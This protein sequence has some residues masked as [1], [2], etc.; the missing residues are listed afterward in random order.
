MAMALWAL[1]MAVLG[2]STHGGAI[3][4]NPT[5][6]INGQVYTI[7][8]IDPGPGNALAVG[9]I[10]LTAGATFQ[11]DYQA[12]VSDLTG[13]N[14]LPIV[15]PGMTSSY[16]LTTVGS[17]TEVVTSLQFNGTLATFACA[18]PVVEQLLR[19]LL[20]S[21]RGR[22]QPRGHRLQRWHLDPGRKAGHH[23]AERS[24]SIR[25]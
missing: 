12:T 25:S 21:G 23:G 7:S 22:Q 8:G 11:L 1:G 6:A 2:S 5:G 14:G 24:G 3:N 19:A 4:F 16:Q 20:Q 15:P 18:Y 17:F 13:T 9:S 10:P